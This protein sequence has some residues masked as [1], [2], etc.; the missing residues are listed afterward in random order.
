MDRSDTQYFSPIL[1]HLLA[2]AQSISPTSSNPG[3]VAAADRKVKYHDVASVD[4]FGVLLPESLAPASYDPLAPLQQ[5]HPKN[6]ARF[7]IPTYDKYEVACML[8]FYKESANI[9][10]M[11]VK[12]SHKGTVVANL[13]IL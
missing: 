11:P 6:L 5:I 13:S 8:K 1:N 3:P 9:K 2:A 7:D 4:S 12:S 10:S